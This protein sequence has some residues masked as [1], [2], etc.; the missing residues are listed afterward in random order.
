MSLFRSL[1]ALK[2]KR[3]PLILHLLEHI[4]DDLLVLGSNRKR[5]STEH[6]GKA[7]FMERPSAG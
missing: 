1:P 4:R 7:K 6:S 5:S 3:K 2:D